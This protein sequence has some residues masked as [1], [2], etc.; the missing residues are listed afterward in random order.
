MQQAGQYAAIAGPLSRASAHM[1]TSPPSSPPSWRARASGAAR[2]RGALLRRREPGLP[3]PTRTVPRAQLWRRRGKRATA[4]RR[5]RTTNLK[6]R[7]SRIV[8]AMASRF[9]LAFRASPPRQLILP[10]RHHRRQ[11]R[12]VII[13]PWRRWS[14]S[15]WSVSVRHRPP[16]WT[17]AS[18][19]LLRHGRFFTAVFPDS[20]VA[21]APS[22]PTHHRP[23]RTTA[24]CP[25]SAVLRQA[26]GRR[27]LRRHRCRRRGEVGGILPRPSWAVEMELF[28]VGWP[29]SSQRDRL[30]VLARRSPR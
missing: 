20:L 2:L 1:F 26:R 16:P 5:R 21:V 8:K 19:M 4:T 12:C 23:E 28:E 7:I 14:A 10:T 15:A 25:T 22:S 27:A 3:P 30:D 24:W 13:V 17:Q 29:R 18:I 11:R 9:P 6:S